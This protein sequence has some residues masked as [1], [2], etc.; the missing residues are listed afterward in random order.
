MSRALW[1]ETDVGSAREAQCL[2]QRIARF[3]L[4]DSPFANA[5]EGLLHR[6]LIQQ[7]GQ[8]AFQLHRDLIKGFPV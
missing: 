1:A 6:T 2:R 4:N 7:S 8:C 5:I 3:P